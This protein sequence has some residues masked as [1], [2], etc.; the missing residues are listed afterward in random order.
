MAR[1]AILAIRIISDATKAAKGFQQAETGTA[2]FE[3]RL[4]TAR[5]TAGLVGV[6]L[7]GAGA[8]AR[9]YASEAQQSAGA[10]EAVFGR[11]AGAVRK[12]ARSAAKDLGLA[13]SEYENMSAVFGAQLKNLG[14]ATEQLVPLNGRL[15]K[16]GGDLA[17]TFGGTTSEAVE[18]LSSLM[19]GERDPIERYGVSIKQADINAQLAAKGQSKLTGA[20]KRQAETEATLALLFKQTAKAQGQRA[21][22][23]GSDAQAAEVASAKMKNAW[24]SFGTAVLPITTAF[25]TGL[26]TAA[27]WAERNKTTVIVLAAV[28][29]TLVTAVYAISAAYAVYNAAVKASILY[30]RLLNVQ[31]RLNPLGLIIT[32]LVAVAAGF[33]IA[34]KRSATFRGIVQAVGRAGQAALGW[35]VAKA[36]DVGTWIRKLG[37]AAT[38]A[39][40][41][42]VAAFKAYTAPIRAVVNLIRDLV[43]KIKGIKWPKPP[44]WLKKAGGVIGGIGGL[45]GSATQFRGGATTGLRPA[46]FAAPGELKASSSSLVTGAVGGRLL[47]GGTVV[48]ITV[49]GAL[50][51]VAVAKQLE[52]ILRG[53]QISLGGA[54]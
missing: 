15:I 21:R 30:Q 33:V 20:A 52:G 1:T 25:A 50:D 32:A 44:G 19:R 38:A 48:Q 29:G 2:K 22:E 35:I 6:A 54:L 42:A 36:R 28:V 3:R 37:P 7:V 11:Q 31:L 43:N 46:V 17:A 40:T 26:A 49:N 34:Y 24:A 10:V 4:G 45:F 16:L 53:R 5:R 14:V 8:A 47:S 13:R 41:V 23:A 51:P 39:K 18:A 12:A 9:K 27:T